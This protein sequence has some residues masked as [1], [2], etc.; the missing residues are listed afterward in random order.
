[1]NFKEEK[2]R[3]KQFSKND[4]IYGLMFLRMKVG[5]LENKLA[6]LEKGTNSEE[7]EKDLS[8]PVPRL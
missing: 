4:L 7:K 2:K 5:Q 3:L 1:M 8:P 6:A